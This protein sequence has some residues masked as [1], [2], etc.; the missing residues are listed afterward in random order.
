MWALREQYAHLA[1]LQHLLMLHTQPPPSRG[2]ARHQNST[3]IFSSSLPFACFPSL[4][5]ISSLVEELSHLPLFPPRALFPQPVI[6]PLWLQG[7]IK[8]SWRQRETGWGGCWVKTEY[9]Y[10]SGW[11]R[12]QGGSMSYISIETCGFKEEGDLQKVANYWSNW[13]SQRCFLINEQLLNKNNV[14]QREKYH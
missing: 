13:S 3:L 7:R 6:S 10:I 11:K 5:P 12:G 2:E 14:I 8:A 4:S 9:F 1:R